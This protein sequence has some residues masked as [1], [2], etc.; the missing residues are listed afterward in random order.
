M[1]GSIL[2][3][4]KAEWKVND[5]GS[6]HWASNFLRNF[7]QMEANFRKM[8]LESPCYFMWFLFMDCNGCQISTLY[9]HVMELVPGRN[10]FLNDLY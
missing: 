3:F 9:N 10:I 7:D 5:T 6:A 8:L 1:G 4:L 2:S